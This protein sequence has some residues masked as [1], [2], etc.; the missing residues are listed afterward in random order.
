MGFSDYKEILVSKEIPLIAVNGQFEL[1]MPKKAREDKYP[2]KNT[3]GLFGSFDTPSYDAGDGLHRL[4]LTVAN[5]AQV[6]KNTSRGPQRGAR[7]WRGAP[8]KHQVVTWAT[9]Y[10]HARVVFTYTNM[11]ISFSLFHR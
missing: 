2:Q 6:N 3:G 4:G 8:L 9:K 7:W 10:S 11:H 5:Q 1:H